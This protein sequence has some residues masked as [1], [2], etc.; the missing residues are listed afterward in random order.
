M[1]ACVYHLAFETGSDSVTPNEGIVGSG[2][3]MCVFLGVCLCVRV[4]V[5]VC[6]C[7]SG[8]RLKG[9]G[10]MSKLIF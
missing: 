10:L 5:C 8:S 6:V 3:C 1:M 2:V 9:D 7:V 4:R